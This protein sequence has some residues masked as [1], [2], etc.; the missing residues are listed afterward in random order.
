MNSTASGSKR[1]SRVSRGP[2][3]RR[4]T[5]LAILAIGLLLWLWP[6]RRARSDNF[7][8]YLPAARQLVAIQVVDNT[9]YLPLLKVL[10]LV[11]TVS[12]TEEKRR[13]LKV[14]V[15]EDRLELHEG[16]TELKLNKHALEL[17]NPVR[18][19]GGVWLVPLEFLDSVLPR[20]TTETIRY[21][22]GDERMF[23]GDVRPATFSA[24]LS[25]ISNGDRLTVNF[26]APVTM[27]T[28][29]T[30]GQW[31]IFLGDGVLM[32]LESQM[33]FQS[34]Y[35]SGVSF[36]DQDGVPKLIITPA[37]ASLNFYPTV[38]EGGK[39][40]QVDVT[41]AASQPVQAAAGAPKAPAGGGGPPGTQAP[42]GAG[43]P[44]TAAGNAAPAGGQ[45]T[46]AAGPSPSAAP[47]PPPLPVVVLDPGHGGADAGALSR[48]GVT[49]RDLAAA[50]AERVRAALVSSGKVRVVLTRTGS[51]D[52][53][54]DERD[55]I[56]NLARPVAFLTLHA[57][58][59]GGSSPAVALYTYQ[60]SSVQASPPALRTLFVPWDEAQQ[61][62][63]T[64]SRDLANLLGQQLAHVQG[65]ETRNPTGAPVR[66][67]RSVDAP[68][69]AI[70]IGTL[71]PGQDAA[72]LT[73]GSFQ[74]QLA[75]AVSAAVTALVGGA[76]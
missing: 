10:S 43:A 18:V 40:F 52:P 75:A 60:A 68:A 25:P 24:R 31:V 22:T 72:T 58:D 27:Q 39:T 9:R 53:G 5:L 63:L 20:L 28:A 67:L 57:G 51:S 6:A 47:P 7:V 15:G 12:D 59:L 13:S 8:F 74:N 34:R 45:T 54:I 44:A 69:V 66:Q 49:E 42:S 3:V 65:L 62:H 64:R 48:D 1:T 55:A 19:A 23:I 73:S 70:E 33:K 61:A 56:A 16:D 11:G 2:L 14:W 71:G 17:S 35:I 38:A 30:N 21:R 50:L 26:T 37:A 36:D 46:A 41:Q 32:P 76:S 4:P 29:S